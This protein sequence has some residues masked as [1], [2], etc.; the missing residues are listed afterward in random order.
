MSYPFNYQYSHQLNKGE[1]LSK[2]IVY[3]F[4]HKSKKAGMCVIMISF[5]Q[6]G[7][8]GSKVQ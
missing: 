3:E 8:M 2:I 7:F 5:A 4:K 6:Q 1:F